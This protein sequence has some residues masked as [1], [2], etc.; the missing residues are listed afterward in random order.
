MATFN[1]VQNWL[2]SIK[3]GSL[4]SLDDNGLGTTVINEKIILYVLANPKPSA[5]SADSLFLYVPLASTQFV[6]D[7]NVKNL[8][9]YVGSQNMMGALGE[10]F[11]LALSKETGLFWLVGRFSTEH[12]TEQEFEQCI[13]S[14]I[15]Y[16]DKLYSELGNILNA[17]QNIT[18]ERPIPDAMNIIW[19]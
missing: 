11:R 9:Y 19:A 5:I 15:N 7:E 10:G 1:K 17:K 12:M 8:L 2:A 4:A 13:D 18:D 3:K 14:C 16:G 6:S